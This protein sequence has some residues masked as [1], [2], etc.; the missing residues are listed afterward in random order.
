M[1]TQNLHSVLP[2]KF[3][4]RTLKLFPTFARKYLEYPRRNSFI[5][6]AKFSEKLTFLTPLCAH[7]RERNKCERNKWMILYITNKSYRK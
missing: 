3:Y 2:E 4:Q 5:T 1:A 6:L 7:E